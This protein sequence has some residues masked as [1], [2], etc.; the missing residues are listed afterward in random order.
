[1][2]VI[3][4]ESLG[5]LQ[6]LQITELFAMKQFWKSAQTFVMREPR[7]QSALL[8][9][10]GA[11]GRFVFENGTE[12][13]VP[14]GALVS[15]PQGAIY[16]VTFLACDK[17]ATV[18]LECC[19]FSE[20]TPFTLNENVE[21]VE[22]LLSDVHITELFLRLV[23]EYA[24]P[25]K[26]YL[27]LRE[28][29]YQLFSLLS[30]REQRRALGIHGFHVIEQGIRYLESDGEQKLS[31]EE[32]AAMCFVTPAYFRRLFRSYAGISP[33][34]YRIRR[35]IERAKELIARSDI[36]VAE[37]SELLDFENPSYFCRVFKKE[38]GVSPSMYRK[39]TLK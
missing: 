31:I 5:A 19:L 1:M 17:P 39:T 9:F 3:P 37:L 38:T 25:Q 13:A 22:R 28:H 8:W 27:S 7:R 11:E 10:C 15:I 26:P 16:S 36:S 29:F 21:I 2:R 30:E 24:M 33:A 35:K 20:E 32:I 23:D 6:N 18:L 4:T 14:R 34:A 12:L